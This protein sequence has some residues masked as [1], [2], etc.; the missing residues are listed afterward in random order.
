M[1]VWLRGSPR[2]SRL[3]SHMRV[4][5]HTGAPAPDGGGA[6]TYVTELLSALSRARNTYAHELILC[7]DGDSRHIAESN[8]E[9]HY[10][11]L[12]RENMELSARRDRALESQSLVQR[13]RRFMRRSR[14]RPVPPIEISW[15]EIYA[16]EHIH[17]LLHLAPCTGTSPGIPFAATVWDLHHRVSPWFPEVSR[18][19][20]WDQREAGYAPLRQAT[21]VYTGTQQGREEIASFF[22]IP[23][24]RIKVLPFATPGFALKAAGAPPAPDLLKRFDLPPDYVFYP[25]QFWPH[26]NH[27]L[28]LEAC[29]I[30]REKSGWQPG[31]VFVGA[32]K[33]NI[34]HVRDYAAR[35]GLESCTSFLGFVEQSELIELYRGAHCLAF[36]TFFGPDN[37]PPLE[38]F[39]LGCPVVASD[40]PGAREQLENAA[41]FVSPVDEGALADAILSLRDSD[42]RRG[43]VSAG[44]IRAS[45]H[46]WDEYAKGVLASLDEFASVRRAWA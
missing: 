11:D 37:L 29:R 27:V 25:A 8:P 45:K 36:P 16:R 1:L 15:E 12:S 10:L 32:D 3:I 26:K 28:I 44:K 30:V 34:C 42:T 9:F 14:S 6:Y 35:L 22:Q 31:A 33:G 18:G 38:A 20:E 40:V 19:R 46:T 17:F 13:I 23:P 39:A 41:I 43:V 4:G 21:F 24:G 7:V 5:I 2:Q